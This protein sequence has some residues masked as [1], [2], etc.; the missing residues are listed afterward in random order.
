[1]K[2]KCSKYAACYGHVAMPLDGSRVSAKKPIDF[3]FC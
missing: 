3:F 2:T 1:M